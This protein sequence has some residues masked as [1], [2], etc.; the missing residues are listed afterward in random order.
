LTGGSAPKTGKVVRRRVETNKTIC[1]GQEEI[2]RAVKK[3]GGAVAL[4]SKQP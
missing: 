3:K 4:T 2:K 1:E